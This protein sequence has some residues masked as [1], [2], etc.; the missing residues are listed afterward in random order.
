MTAARFA[1]LAA[2]N[3][4]AADYV[5]SACPAAARVF[6]DAARFAGCAGKIEGR[7]EAA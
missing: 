4:E 6:D 1:F 5:R 2:L 7:A 3:A